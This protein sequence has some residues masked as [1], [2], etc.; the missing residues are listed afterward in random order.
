MELSPME[1]DVLISLANGHT[2]KR[3]SVRWGVCAGTVKKRI[4]SLYEKL[5][6]VSAGQ[7][8]ANAFRAGLFDNPTTRVVVV[9]PGDVLLIH[10]DQR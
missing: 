5:D 6:A 7:A 10:K 1:M 9:R 4:K 3:I 2:I 8:V